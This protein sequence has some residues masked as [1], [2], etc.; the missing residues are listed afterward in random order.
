M[1]MW[2]VKQPRLL[3]AMVSMSEVSYNFHSAITCC[4]CLQ[5]CAIF[6]QCRFLK[7]SHEVGTLKIVL[8]FRVL[9]VSRWVFAKWLFLNF[10]NLKF[11]LKNNMISVLLHSSF[12]GLAILNYCF[13]FVIFY[14]NHDVAFPFWNVEIFDWCPNNWYLP[15][16]TVVQ[17][18]LN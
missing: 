1:L 11:S 4:R 7:F 5:F 10:L 17:K 13:F 3:F 2:L 16:S 8:Y 18:Y 6:S 14:V 12:W 9:L 15:Y